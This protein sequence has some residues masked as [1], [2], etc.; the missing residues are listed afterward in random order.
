MTSDCCYCCSNPAHTVR[1][2][3]VVKGC[4]C[5]YVLYANGQHFYNMTCLK[6]SPLKCDWTMDMDD[7]IDLKCA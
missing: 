3:S 1:L 2:C 5:M 7:I 4:T 6:K